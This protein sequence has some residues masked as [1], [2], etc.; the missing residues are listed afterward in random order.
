MLQFCF[1]PQRYTLRSWCISS[2]FSL[3]WTYEPQKWV[4]DSTTA[5]YVQQQHLLWSSTAARLCRWD[6]LCPST[7]AMN[8]PSSVNRHLPP[9]RPPSVVSCSYPVRL[10]LLKRILS[11]RRRAA[12]RAVLQS[13]PPPH[14]SVG[15]KARVHTIPPA[16]SP[17]SV[18]TS[19]VP[20]K[21]YFSPSSQQL[22]TGTKEEDLCSVR[23]KQGDE[24]GPS[25]DRS[26][27]TGQRGIQILP[28]SWFPSGMS[29]SQAIKRVHSEKQP[30]LAGIKKFRVQFSGIR[31]LGLVSDFLNEFKVWNRL[32]SL[33]SV[34]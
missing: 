5:I 11:P 14:N 18:V 16:A 22:R 27:H 7:V 2:L 32:F 29:A 15:A 30:G 6:D 26:H 9:R 17:Y 21:P 19:N 1:S 34:V 23:N 31:S 10:E 12:R 33:F 20:L 28:K 3:I 4:S 8:S 13:S 24:S 25:T